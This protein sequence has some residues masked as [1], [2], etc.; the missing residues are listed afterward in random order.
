M[1]IGKGMDWYIA[2]AR[3]DTLYFL[4]RYKMERLVGLSLDNGM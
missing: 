3:E 4:A 1:V 2:D